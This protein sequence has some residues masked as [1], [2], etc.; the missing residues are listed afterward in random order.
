MAD[1]ADKERRIIGATIGGAAGGAVGAALGGR[2][3]ATIGG[4][5]SSLIGHWVEHALR[6]WAARRHPAGIVPK[7]IG[8][9]Q[10][11]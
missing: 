10:H 1:K 4:G 6:R 9:A 7:T 5:V 8:Q 3:G 2:I 11:V